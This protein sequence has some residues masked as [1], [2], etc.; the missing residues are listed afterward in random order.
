M[1]KHSGVLMKLKFSTWLQCLLSE[2]ACK[3]LGILSVALMLMATFGLDDIAISETIS[4]APRTLEEQQVID[5]YK[6][7]NP[8]VV[9]ITTISL[10]FDLFAGVQPQE[11]TGSGVVI[12][13]KRGLVI[14]NFH[15]IENAKQVEVALAG[16]QSRVAK[17]VGVDPDSD[18]AVLRLVDPPNDLVA[19]PFGDSSALEIGQRVLAIGNPF[20][21]DRTL[22]SGIVSSLNRSIKRPDGSLMRGLIQI[23]AAIN[24]GNSGG[25]LIDTAGRLVGI[26]TAILSRSGDSAGIGFCVPINQIKRVLPELIATGKVLRPEFGWILIDTDQGPMIHQVV[27]NGAAQRAGVNP[28]LRRVDRDFISGYLRDFSSA[29]LIYKVNGTQVKSKDEVDDLVASIENPSAGIEF[30]LRRGGLA[31]PARKLVIKPQLR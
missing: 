1:K 12:D 14:T 27:P 18:L 6:R 11:G 17:L 9:F 3:S 13:A 31:G 19:L 26:N 25:P 30:E 2:L 20:G 4:R 21:L 28:V 15:V 7:M 16:G 22:S 5:V 8:G 29:D 23:D 10:T 24:V